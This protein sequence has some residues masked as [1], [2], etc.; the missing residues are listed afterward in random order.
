RTGVLRQ[1][2]RRRRR[3]RRGSRVRRRLGAVAQ[4]ADRVRPKLRAVDAG[5]HDRRRRRASGGAFPV[6]QHNPALLILTALPL[7]GSLGVF[8]LR[9]AQAKLAKQLSLAVSLVVVVYTLTVL[10]SFDTGSHAQRFQF[11]GS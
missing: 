11:V 8:S 6:S 3:E 10:F 5:R 1:P 4:V 2:R 9:E 7:I